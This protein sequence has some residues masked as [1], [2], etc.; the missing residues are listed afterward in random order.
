MEVDVIPTTEF[1]TFSISSS[2]PSDR[3]SDGTVIG[4]GG[5]LDL[6]EVDTTD[7]AQDSPVKV[8]WWRVADMKSNTEI[9]NIRIWISDT[10]GLV[11]LDT[12]YMDIT[13]SWVQGKTPVQVQTGSPGNAPTSEPSA[14]LTKIGGGTIT[15]TTHDQTSQYIYITGN[16]GVNETTGDKSGLKITVKFEYR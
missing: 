12:W 15:G 13:D 11:G 16:I 8:I 3:I 6:G 4:T 1:R 2:E 5:S 14:N 10:T 9:F 7:E